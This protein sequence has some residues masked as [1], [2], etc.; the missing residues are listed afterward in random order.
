MKNHWIETVIVVIFIGL[1]AVAATAEEGR[2]A[3]LE[4]RLEETKARLNLTDEQ[5]EQIAPTLLQSFESSRAI[6]QKYGV[7]P[8]SRGN[9]K[10]L[11]L[12]KA[13]QLRQELETLQVNT[14]KE[15]NGVLT[16]EQLA[17]YR[18]I[19]AE[20][21][22]ALQQR[23]FQQRKVSQGSQPQDNAIMF[24]RQDNRIWM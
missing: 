18:Q 12:K 9:G 3:Q 15:L 10:R 6:L 1:F 14:L 4:Q 22:A 7:D 20:R 2:S 21:K 16:D 24:V 8:Q 23:I 17:E 13:R 5:A 11:G 19:Q